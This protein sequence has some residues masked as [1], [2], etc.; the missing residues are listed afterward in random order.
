MKLI[1]KVMDH[2]DAPQQCW[3]STCVVIAIP[4]AHVANRSSSSNM[5]M[6]MNRLRGLGQK[7]TSEGAMDVEEVEVP[8]H[9]PRWA[10]RN[11]RV[12]L[13]KIGVLMS[14]VALQEATAEWCLPPQPGLDGVPNSE[15]AYTLEDVY[16]MVIQKSYVLPPLK[17]KEAPTT[18]AS[19]C[20]HPKRSLKGGGNASASYVV[21]KECQTRWHNPLRA[22]KLKEILEKGGYLSRVELEAMM[23]GE[24][25]LAIPKPSI[26]EATPKLR[27]QP[28]AEAEYQVKEL[29]G[30]L[31]LGLESQA[32]DMA[33]ELQKVQHSRDQEIQKRMQDQERAM[34]KKMN[35]MQEKSLRQE[36]LM[37]AWMKEKAREESPGERSIRAASARSQASSSR[38]KRGQIP[39]CLCKKEAERLMV[40]KEGPRQ[41]RFFYKCLQR[42]CQFFEWEKRTERS[43]S[44]KRSVLDTPTS[45]KQAEMVEIVS[46]EEE[47][48]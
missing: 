41:G 28:S 39:L 24:A 21:C 31:A 19:S 12:I 45:W 38:P 20:I 17:S 43:K 4:K 44:P 33:K 14:L 36:A 48:L 46:S 22:A 47:I 37:Q 34:E 27:A 8:G 1:Q 6:L 35:E 11:W 25:P 23:S 16:Y 29:A 40:K 15:E 3:L 32:M 9:R 13:D 18:A 7:L 26:M 30:Q 5:A 2:L 10:L 42:E